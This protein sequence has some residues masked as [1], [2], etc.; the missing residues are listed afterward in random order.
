MEEIWVDIK[1]YEGDY[2]I[3]NLARIRSLDRIIITKAG[4]EKPC[5]S[6]IIVPHIYSRGYY[7]FSLNKDGVKNYGYPH[8]LMAEHF[9]PNPEGK[10][11]VHHKNEIKTDNRIENLQ[12]ATYQENTLA[13]VA[14]GTIKCKGKDNPMYGKRGK[15]APAYGRCKELSAMYGKKGEDALNAKII[16]HI[17][18]GVFYFGIKAAADSI[19]MNYSTLAGQLKGH[20]KNNTPF[21]YV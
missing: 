2:Q 10:K 15:N 8:V 13:S 1:G 3:S 12:W 16:L 6:Q 17:E 19:N 14:T 4:W 5:K 20:Y 7:R 21:R 9:I 18:T 11:C